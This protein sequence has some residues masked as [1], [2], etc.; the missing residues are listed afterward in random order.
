M[1]MLRF[2]EAV[3]EAAAIEAA[4][5]LLGLDEYRLRR[6]GLEIAERGPGRPID[7]LGRAHL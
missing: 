4:V 7:W 1:Q 2:V 5:A 6:A 3:S